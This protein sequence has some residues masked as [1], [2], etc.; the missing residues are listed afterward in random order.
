M[1]ITVKGKENSCI[2]MGAAWI[3]LVLVLKIMTM[4]QLPMAMINFLLIGLSFSFVLISYIRNQENNWELYLFILAFAVHMLV[5]FVDLYGKNYVSILYSG[6][7]TEVFFDIASRYYC[8]DFSETLTFYPYFLNAFFQIIGV[9][10]IGV[11]YM[12]VLAWCFSM[13]LMELCCDVL[14]IRKKLRFLAL[15]LMAFLPVYLCTTSILLREGII[16]AMNM[17]W[18]YCQMKWMKTGKHRYLLGCL[19]APLISVALH[20]SAI[21]FFGITV[22]MIALYDSKKQ[23]LRIQ[24]KTL[25]IIL[26]GIVGLVIF[27]VIPI[28]RRFIT[29]K[30]PDFDEGFFN[31]INETIA[32]VSK[33]SSGS[34]YLRDV[35]VNGFGDFILQTFV[36]MFYFYASPLPMHWRGISDVAAFVISSGFYLTS[37]VISLG[38]IF[39]KKKDPYRT[40]MWLTFL[41]LSGISCWGVFNSAT[42]MRHR[43]KIVGVCILLA[44]YSLNSIKNA[45]KSRRKK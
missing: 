5:L 43:D 19:T 34:M 42:A 36:R 29:L 9:N 30:L 18:F 16:T 7:D 11:Q 10:R 1:N 38:T 4:L 33:S 15:F 17:L 31:T 14:E 23:E 22:L 37:I 25:M 44:V 45:C 40:L 28:T 2:K 8:G 26:A 24:K 20:M 3:L 41:A 27:L 12:N 21:V 6:K 39:V 32:I 35:Y 13:V